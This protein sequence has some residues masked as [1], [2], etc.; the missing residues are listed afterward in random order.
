MLAFSCI[1]GSYSKLILLVESEW[2]LE[3]MI[4]REL[5]K[6]WLTIGGPCG[7]ATWL[8]EVSVK[9]YVVF[10]NIKLHISRYVLKF[11]SNCLDMKMKCLKW[12]INQYPN[13]TI[14]LSKCIEILHSVHKIYPVGVHQLKYKIVLLKTR[15]LQSSLKTV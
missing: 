13:L 8:L 2:S 7:I 6:G 1:C 15:N 12:W 5:E 9:V 11:I 10:N 3:C 14:E 4:A